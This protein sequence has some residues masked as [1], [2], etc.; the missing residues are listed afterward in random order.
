VTRIPLGRI[1]L[2]EDIADAV[3]FLASEQ[4]RLV[5]G[6]TIHVDGRKVAAATIGIEPT[7]FPQ[8]PRPPIPVERASLAR[9][10]H[11]AEIE[12]WLFRQPS[13]WSLRPI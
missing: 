9:I 1:G 7:D 11:D 8:S 10:Q 4:A 5:T 6:Q 3:I 12:P 13:I 2:P